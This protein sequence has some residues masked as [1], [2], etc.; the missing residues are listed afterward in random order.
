[1][2]SKK[3]G[4]GTNQ[5][6]VVEL[7]GKSRF[8]FKGKIKKL[9]SSTMSEVPVT[10][11]TVI[12]T[13][14]EVFQSP[15]VLGDL[16]GKEIRV[17]LKKSE[18]VRTGQRLIF[19]ANSWL[20]G[21]GVAVIEVGRMPVKDAAKLSKNINDAKQII[22]DKDLQDR[23]SRAELIVVGK[24]SKTKPAAK[25]PSAITTF[26]DPI[27]WEA[28]IE[29]ES[30]EKGQLEQK[31]N[32]TTVFPASTDEAWIDSPKFREGQKGVWILQKDQQEKGMEALRLSGN[33]A[34]HPLNFQPMD[35][36]GR[37]KLLIKKRG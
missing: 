17:E 28:T 27:W 1:M 2:N 35:Q 4:R 36:L 19:F 33:T 10:A 29:I 20:Y 9:N 25:V 30:I 18:G 12:L 15:N 31:R 34:L 37:I 16:T 5:L 11:N 24:V 13:V 14:E 6:N 22:R 7:I 3:Q 32:I 23:I 21:K 26:H 8:C